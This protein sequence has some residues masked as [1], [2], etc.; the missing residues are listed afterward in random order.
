MF[1]A[2]H[3]AL[4]AQEDGK[5][6]LQK[7]FLSGAGFAT[8]GGITFAG[9][10]ALFLASVVP[11]HR[12]R[13]MDSAPPAPRH[14][15]RRRA[16]FHV[17]FDMSSSA[18]SSQLRRSCIVRGVHGVA[19]CVGRNFLALRRACLLPSRLSD[20]AVPFSRAAWSWRL[21]YQWGVFP[22]RAFVRVVSLPWR[23]VS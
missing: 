8:S 21:D 19:R 7:D 17:G 1:S 12:F 18:C 5:E 13:T 23:P 2:L 16:D 22:S 3:A 10:R 4:D 15:A 20:R 11:S 14:W 9:G 6:A